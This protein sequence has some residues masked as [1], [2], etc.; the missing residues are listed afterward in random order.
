MGKKSA[1]VGR[2]FFFIVI[3]FLE[4]LIVW[5]ICPYKKNF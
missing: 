3:P 1:D 4:P 5:T 2:F